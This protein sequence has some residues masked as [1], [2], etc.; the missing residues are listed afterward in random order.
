[1]DRIFGSIDVQIQ[2]ASIKLEAS[3]Q[4]ISGSEVGFTRLP[5]RNPSFC[6]ACIGFDNSVVHSV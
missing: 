1:M 2:P 3:H 5:L 4:D 6:I